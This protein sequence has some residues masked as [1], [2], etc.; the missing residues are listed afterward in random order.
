MLAAVK[1][2]LVNIVEEAIEKK[3]DVNS[4]DSHVSYTLWDNK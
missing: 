1:G 4:Q 3:V 2:E